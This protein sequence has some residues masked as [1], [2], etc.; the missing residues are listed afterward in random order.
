MLDKGRELWFDA[1]RDGL[2]ILVSE[3]K[4][5]QADWPLWVTLVKTRDLLDHRLHR[6]IQQFTLLSILG[7]ALSKSVVVVVQSVVREE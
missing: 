6:L 4:V 7:V 5:K 1:E 2:R 3:R